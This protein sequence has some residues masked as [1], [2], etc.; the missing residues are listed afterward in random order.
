MQDLR[1]I[2]W[3]ALIP[4]AFLFWFS[5]NTVES[6]WG[7][8]HLLSLIPLYVA[9]WALAAV[10]FAIYAAIVMIVDFFLYGF[11]CD[12]LPEPFEDDFPLAL[13]PQPSPSDPHPF[14]PAVGPP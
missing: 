12:Y 13:H 3:T 7:A 5:L 8:D 10:G 11:D 1:F 2:H 6:Q 9:G 4:T 14:D